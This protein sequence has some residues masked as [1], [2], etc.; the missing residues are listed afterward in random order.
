MAEFQENSVLTAKFKSRKE[1]D[2]LEQIHTHTQ[3]NTDAETLVLKNM[4]VIDKLFS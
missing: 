1:M 4:E 2:M 3:N